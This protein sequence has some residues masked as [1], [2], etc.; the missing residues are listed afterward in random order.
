MVV[1]DEVQTLHI[2]KLMPLPLTVSCS[3]EYRLVLTFLVLPF[4]YLLTRVV[5][6]ISQKSRKTVV[7]VCVFFLL[8]RLCARVVECRSFKECLSRMLSDSRVSVEPY[9]EQIRERVE[10]TIIA[11]HDKTAVNKTAV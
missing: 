9:E 4:W 2:A 1:W 11:L 3:S 5:P 6:D 8:Q 7:C 10:A